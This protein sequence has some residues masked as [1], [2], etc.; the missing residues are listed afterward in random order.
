MRTCKYFTSSLL[1]DFSRYIHKPDARPVEDGVGFNKLVF[2]LTSD[3]LAEFIASLRVLLRDAASR[4]E[5]EGSRRFNLGLS[6]MPGETMPLT[7]E[8]P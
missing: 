7:Q 8:D 3:E 6:I 2:D 4:P 5:R 1:G